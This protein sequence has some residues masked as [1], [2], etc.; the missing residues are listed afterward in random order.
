[1]GINLNMPISWESFKELPARIQTEY[2]RHLMNEY[3]ANAT[4]LAAMFSIQPLTVRRYLAAKVLD[5]SFPVGHSMNAEQ[6][7]AWEAFLG[8]VSVQ[9]VT[10]D[11]PSCDVQQDT[12]GYSM[13]V[14]RVTLS[15]SGKINIA[16]ISNSLV[17]LIGD[18]AIGEV[19]ITCNLT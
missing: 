17:Y 10:V 16:E 12:Q 8:G 11:T 4:S 19:E 14:K 9:T 18:D 13:S 1:M 15:F 2:V 7:K 3:G 6:R 5:V